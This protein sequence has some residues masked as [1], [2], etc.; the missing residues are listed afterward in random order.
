VIKRPLLL[1][2]TACLLA[3]GLGLYA[4][5]AIFNL[6]LEQHA[7]LLWLGVCIGAFITGLTCGRKSDG[8]ASRELAIAAL[9]AV[10]AAGCLAV[11]THT[12]LSMSSAPFRALL[13]APL[14]IGLV[15]YFGASWGYLLWGG[16]RL[17]WRLGYEGFVGR[18]FLLHKSS[19]VLS[20]VTTLSVMGVALGVWLVAVS[21][22]ILSGFEND[23]E[24][25]II[26]ANA[27]ALITKSDSEPFALTQ[28][29]LSKAQKTPGIIAVSPYVTGEVAIASASNYT[30]A[31]LFGIDPK[32]SQTVLKVFKN[33]RAGSLDGL[34]ENRDPTVS[35]SIPKLVLGIEMAKALNV[36]VG[37]RV[38]VISPAQEILTPFGVMPKTLTFEVAG[39]F[40]TKMY[41][42]DSRYAYVSLAPA[43][44]FFELEPDN[45]TGL[46]VLTDD[47][48]FSERASDNVASQLQLQS[49]DWK[50][51]NQTLFA[52]LKL[53]RVVAFVVLVFIILVASFSIVNTL[54]MSVIEKAKEIAILKTM[55]AKNVGIMK[56]FLV[57]G[58]IVG[59]SGVC[60]GALM[61]LG[62]VV[63]LQ[64]FGFWIPQDVYYI[65]A[66]PVD[67]T[68][69]DLL[70]VVLAAMLIVWNFAVY[71]AL[72]GAQLTPVEGLRDG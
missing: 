59:A 13:I 49:L 43:R 44:R 37:E 3:L 50:A 68:I 28:E 23:L 66:L 29:M 56:L 62:T 60:I 7:S 27:H 24:K 57:Q 6:N 53:E 30:V 72:R 21:L 36:E 39:I 58:L 4:L 32:L 38:R 17:D 40:S 64:R 70:L 45:V 11:V 46:H 10:L 52:S 67:L 55:G 48:Q 41:E 33:M 47:P 69:S 9:L 15:A 16:G 19:P 2:S 25:K 34:F 5:F 20:T 8:I 35:K 14:A 61:A 42:Y 63:V 1:Q 54:T 31:E 71:P 51:R 26:G 22:G 18:R 65:D 12:Q